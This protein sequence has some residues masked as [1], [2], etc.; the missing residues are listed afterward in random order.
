[1]FWNPDE[2]AVVNTG[3]GMQKN[4][5]IHALTDPKE[6][7]QTTSSLSQALSSFSSLLHQTSGGSEDEGG[8]DDGGDGG[9]HAVVG[10]RRYFH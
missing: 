1:M 2:Y 9:G 3:G 6:I 8:D 7:S 5:N 10:F 4:K